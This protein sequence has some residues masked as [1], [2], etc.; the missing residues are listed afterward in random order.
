MTLGRHHFAI[1]RNT[2]LWHQVPSQISSCFMWNRLGV[3]TY[4]NN[5]PFN[6]FRAISRNLRVFVPPKANPIVKLE[7]RN[8]RRKSS[9]AH[10]GPVSNFSCDLGH[11]SKK[12]KALASQSTLFAT[13]THSSHIPWQTNLAESENKI[14]PYNIYPARPPCYCKRALSQQRIRWRV[15]PNPNLFQ[16]RSDTRVHSRAPGIIYW[17]CERESGWF[18]L[19]A[20]RMWWAI[21]LYTFLL[22]TSAVARLLCMNKQTE[23]GRF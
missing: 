1:D 12:K 22:P 11:R 10:P 2:K 18:R 15:Q 3:H 5:D 8:P 14:P 13:Q 20:A 6:G 21:K 9:S 19:L 17:E 23:G 4:K 7:K 16:L